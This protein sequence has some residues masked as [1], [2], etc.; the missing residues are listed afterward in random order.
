VVFQTS[1]IEAR[2]SRVTDIFEE[3]YLDRLPHILLAVGLLATAVALATLVYLSR[4][5]RPTSKPVAT[6]AS[7]VVFETAS[8]LK[9]ED[10]RKQI[11]KPHNL[12]SLSAKVPLKYFDVTDEQ[13]PKRFKITGDID[14]APTAVV[15]DIYGRE[16]A[17]I[18]GMPKSFDAFQAVLVPI[19]RRA[20]RDVAETQK[21]AR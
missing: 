10:F 3:K 12:G 7:V 11:G 21:L 18:T 9:C 2:M 14:E 17:R 8:C 16:V 19:M 6:T 13:P 1:D 4:A 20:E 5:V 15:F